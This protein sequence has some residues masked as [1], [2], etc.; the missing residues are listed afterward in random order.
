MPLCI[1]RPL[2]KMQDL[3]DVEACIRS[4][5]NTTSGVTCQAL[6]TMEFLCWRKQVVQRLLSSDAVNRGELRVFLS[7]YKITM[8]HDTCVIEQLLPNVCSRSGAVDEYNNDQSPMLSRQVEC[9]DVF[10]KQ[11]LC[12]FQP[13]A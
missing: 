10:K 3:S 9:Q 5:Y 6:R 2:A 4:V 8:K 1:V 11:R 7:G 13:L 12:H